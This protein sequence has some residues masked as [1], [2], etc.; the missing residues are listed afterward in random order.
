[1]KLG[2]KMVEAEASAISARYISFSCGARDRAGRECGALLKRCESM[3]LVRAGGVEILTQ[4][5]Q[6]RGKFEAH[7]VPV[8]S[9]GTFSHRS[10]SRFRGA[11]PVLVHITCYVSDLRLVPFDANFLSLI[12]D[13]IRALPSVSLEKRSKSGLSCSTGTEEGWFRDGNFKMFYCDLR[14]LKR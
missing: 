2:T 9:P 8:S 13:V 7:A 14:P 3:M 4:P 6:S 10:L 12:L 11:P 5:S 1:M